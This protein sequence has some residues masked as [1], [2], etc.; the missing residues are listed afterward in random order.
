MEKIRLAL[1]KWNVAPLS[2]AVFLA[3]LLYDSTKFYQSSSC[4][5]PEW[6]VA[7]LF[8]YFAALAGLI[9]KIY[10]SLQRDRNADSNN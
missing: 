3:W 2:I 1:I 7:A 5:L 9:Y 10:D 8:T 4:T 6:H